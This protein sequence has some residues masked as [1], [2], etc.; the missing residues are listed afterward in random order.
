MRDWILVCARV[1]DS[2]RCDQNPNTG[3]QRFAEFADLSISD[4]AHA[5]S[6]RPGQPM[7]ILYRPSTGLLVSTYVHV[8]YAVLL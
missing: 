4:V 2:R 6:L 1:I 8:C 7:G 3:D 5:E